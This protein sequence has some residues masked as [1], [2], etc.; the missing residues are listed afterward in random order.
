MDVAER[1][2]KKISKVLDHAPYK[3]INTKIRCSKIRVIDYTPIRKI[4]AVRRRPS[5]SSSDQ[6]RAITGRYNPSKEVANIVNLE[7]HHFTKLKT[8]VTRVTT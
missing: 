1:L 8:T 7:K 6:Y 2:Y 4:N 3:N 5:L